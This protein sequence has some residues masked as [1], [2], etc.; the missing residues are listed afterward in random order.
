MIVLPMVF[1]FFLGSVFNTQ[2]S[3]DNRPVV[4]RV[5]LGQAGSATGGIESLLA[6]LRAAQSQFLAQALQRA[7]AGSALITGN[8]SIADPTPTRKSAN[9]DSHRTARTN[10]RRVCPDISAPPC[11]K[12]KST[13]VLFLCQYDRIGPR[14]RG[15]RLAG[16]P[17]PPQ[18]RGLATEPTLAL[19]QG[20][21]SIIDP[22]CERRPGRDGGGMVLFD[23]RPGRC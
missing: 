6:Q 17:A 18:A 13:S 9:G 15:P 3:M 12:A 10:V 5:N 8:S 2:E 16:V 19:V 22:S 21:L 20:K 1:T 23:F 4:G 11:A 7:T 14:G